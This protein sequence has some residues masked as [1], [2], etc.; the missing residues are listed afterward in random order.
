MS[1]GAGEM[2]ALGP[3]VFSLDSAPYQRL[4]RRTQ[5][6]WASL[7]R[8]GRAP[9][10]QYLG[11]AAEEITL[12]GVLLPDLG[13]HSSLESLRELAREGEPHALVD[14]AGHNHGL[15]VVRELSEDQ[16]A[17]LPDGVPLR[18]AFRLSLTEYGEDEPAALPP[19]VVV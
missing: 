7:A 14:G 16:D 11:P 2:M 15:W 10:L 4:S 17:L 1:A 8:L 18:R 6:R 19:T 9:A 3:F 12:E 13:D 5:A